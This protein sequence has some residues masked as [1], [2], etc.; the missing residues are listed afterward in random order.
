MS[1]DSVIKV[2]PPRLANQIAAGEVVERPASVVKELMENCLDAGASQ[3]EIDVEKGGTSLIRVRD[4]GLGLAKVDLPLAL[5]RHATSKIVKLDDLEAVGTL[6]FRGEALASISSVSRMS[7]TSKRKGADQAFSVSAEGREMRADVKPAAH[8]EGSSVEV[9]DLFFNT[10]ARRK[11]LRT[12]KT[13]YLRIDEVVRRLALSRYDVGFTLRHN[14][15]V[16]HTL[17]PAQ[18]QFEKDRRVA[19]ICGPNF[20]NAALLIDEERT[21]LRLWGWV[22]RPEFSRSQADLQ[23]FFVNGRVIRDK[24]VSHAVR[25]AYQDVLF[26][27]RHPAFVL[28]LELDAATVDVNVHPTK[29]EVRFRDQRLVHNFL[30]SALHS[31]LAATTDQELVNSRQAGSRSSMGQALASPGQQVAAPDEIKVQSRLGLL[32]EKSIRSSG[33]NFSSERTA[34]VATHQAAHS[35]QESLQAYKALLHPT[36]SPANA[37]PSLAGS[38]GL[39][40]SA[41]SAADIP[42]LGYALAQLKG[43]YILAENKEGLIIVDTHAAHERLVYEGMKEQFALQRLQSQPLLIPVSVSLSSKEV[44][45]AEQHRT[46]LQQLGFGV[47]VSSAESVIIRELPALLIKSDA[48]ALLRDTLSDL[49]TYGDSDRINE[50]INEILSTMAC[51]GSV[52][53]NRSLSIEEMNRL[54]RDMEHTERSGQCNHGRPTWFGTSLAELDAVFMR[55]R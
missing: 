17:R 22:A 10:P 1:E 44:A 2:L 42:P 24:L 49:L 18:S 23:Y 9:R 34:P 12:E 16:V 52:R 48:P 51:H 30:F 41:D 33:S 55:G 21:G 46:M 11:F 13:E 37:S 50:S 3:I 32:A 20:M 36:D 47:E 6:G 38:P 4:N 43:V 39:S 35:V 54:L 15:Q 19:A 5:S 45:C 26:H 53:A 25:K 28:Y 31:A 27:G 29:H 7:M 40:G 8:P 14:Q